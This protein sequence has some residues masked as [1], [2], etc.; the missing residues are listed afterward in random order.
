MRLRVDLLPHGNYPDVVLVVDVLRATTTAVTYLERGAD[1]LLIERAAQL[2]LPKRAI[3][4]ADFKKYGFTQF[5]KL[6]FASWP[7]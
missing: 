2:G 6:H 1:A 7:C 5:D 4:A 3:H